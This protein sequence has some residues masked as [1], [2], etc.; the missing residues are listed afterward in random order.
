MPRLEKVKIKGIQSIK[1]LEIKLSPCLTA[2]VG[3][4]DAGKTAF[5]RAIETALLNCDAKDVV[6]TG[7]QESEIE[8]QFEQ[9]D[10]VGWKRRKEK[11]HGSVSYMVNGVPSTKMGRNV[12]EEVLKL[13]SPWRV[14]GEN[15]GL[16]QIHSQND[17][18][19]LTTRMTA[20]VGRA[21]DFL[22]GRVYRQAIDNC[23][24]EIR[25]KTAEQSSLIKSLNSHSDFIKPKMFQLDDLMIKIKKLKREVFE[26][27]LILLLRKQMFLRKVV[28]E[29][30]SHFKTF[31]HKKARELKEID[32]SRDVV[33]ATD[34]VMALKA[35]MDFERER[36]IWL[37]QR[38]KLKILEAEIA[39][40]LTCPFYLK[41]GECQ[42]LSIF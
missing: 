4:G 16:L 28:R 15:F 6:R 11:T 42:L 17:L 5:I 21:W 13:A 27:Q 18:P 3:R 32:L 33:Q 26:I 37:N 19:F 38:K 34:F 31:Y 14:E 36:V 10:R 30:N 7:E 40:R 1:D 9:G 23:K 29:L 24:S 41:T 25:K 22:E 8:L 2:I 39:E 20:K 35:K 12:P